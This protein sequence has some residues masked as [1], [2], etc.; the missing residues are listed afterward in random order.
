MEPVVF[1]KIAD[2]YY[3]YHNRCG[4]CNG[5]L[6]DGKLEGTTLSCASCGRQYEV[7]RAGRCLDDPNLF[8]EAVPLLVE[9]GKV[10]VAL[11]ALENDDQSQA[12]LSTHA[13]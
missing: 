2:T 11:A 13:R 4:N 5:P 10:K 3:A 9:S 8:L 1:C 12:A 6:D 7:S